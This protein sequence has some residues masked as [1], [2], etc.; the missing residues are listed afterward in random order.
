M[1][2]LCA[3]SSPSTEGGGA[4]R[5]EWLSVFA[6]SQ[7]LANPNFFSATAPAKQVFRSSKRP[8]PEVGQSKQVKQQ[9]RARKRIWD[10][11]TER[12]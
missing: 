11:A 5:R 12:Q 4:E 2:A 7:K 6:G 3:L 1:R 9:A 8:R 10:G